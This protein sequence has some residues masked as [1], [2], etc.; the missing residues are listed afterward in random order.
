MVYKTALKNKRRMPVFPHRSFAKYI[1]L[2]RNE[3][4]EP[5]AAKK[6]VPPFLTGRLQFKLTHYYFSMTIFCTKV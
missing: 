3:D 4:V 5:A 1:C 2:C 6:N